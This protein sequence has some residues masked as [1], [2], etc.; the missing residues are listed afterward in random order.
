M[1]LLIRKIRVS[2]LGHTSKHASVGTVK[3]ISTIM[4]LGVGITDI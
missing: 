4:N 1:Y 3:V 2:F